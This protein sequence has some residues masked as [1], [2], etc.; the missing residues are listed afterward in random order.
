MITTELSGHVT[1]YYCL[2]TDQKPEI[3]YNGS[4]LLEIDTKKVY[5]FDG[6]NREWREI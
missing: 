6:A 5:I 1:T 2:S 4:A 3:A